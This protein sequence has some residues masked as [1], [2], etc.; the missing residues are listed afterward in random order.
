MPNST[1]GA[2]LTLGILASYFCLLIGGVVGY[3]LNI[4]DLVSAAVHA[5]PLTVEIIVRGIGVFVFP[6]GAIMGYF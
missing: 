4:I 6:L 2:G 5:S 1:K 3:V